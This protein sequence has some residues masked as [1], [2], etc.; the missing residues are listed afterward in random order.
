MNAATRNRALQYSLVRVSLSP[1]AIA[2]KISFWHE[3]RIDPMVMHRQ[4]VRLDISSRP[5]AEAAWNCRPDIDAG[6]SRP[7]DCVFGS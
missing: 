7:A 3:Y 4:S 2:L 6:K 5:P 1:L